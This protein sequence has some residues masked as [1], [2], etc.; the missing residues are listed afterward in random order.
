MGRAEAGGVWR[1]LARRVAG[2]TGPRDL[3]PCTALPA[4]LHAPNRPWLPLAASACLPPV[5]SP[6]NA[7]HADSPA[8]QWGRAMPGRSKARALVVVFQRGR[9]IW[10]QG[11]SL[12]VEDGEVW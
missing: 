10:S 9:Q 11:A 3:G 6:P 8:K 4:L 12:A 5:A 1:R 7:E 2:T